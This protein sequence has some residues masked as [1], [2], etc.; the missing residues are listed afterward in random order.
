[1]K[2][3]K[4][5]NKL[6]DSKV[7]R[8]DL[9]IYVLHKG[10]I[11]LLRGLFASPFLTRG[12]PFFLGRGVRIFHSG[13][14]RFGSCVY[15]G[16]YSVINMLST[17]GVSLGDNVTIREYC[18]MQLTS[19]IA[20][21]GSLIDIGDNT[22]IGPRANIGAAGNLVIG[23]RCQVGA[24]V[25]FVAENHKFSDSTEIYNQGVT[26]KGIEIGNDCW[27]GNC[28]VILDGVT[29]GNGC[30]VGAGAIVTKSFPSGS[31]IAGNPAKVIKERLL[32]A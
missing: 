20:D 29:L 22:Y 26:R 24:A 11:P 7:S 23:A 13:K 19:G 10:V 9:C 5:V 4:V 8:V 2:L 17:R 1:M 16:D 3:S 12:F 31:V 21:P 18:W 30:V 27:I 32:H 14:G 28:A 15:I 25:S 6:A